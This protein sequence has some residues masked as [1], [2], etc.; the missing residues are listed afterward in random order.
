ME[1]TDG[2]PFSNFR[3][4]IL[5][6]KFIF[7]ILSNIKVKNCKKSYVIFIEYVKA[8]VILIVHSEKVK[9]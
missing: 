6:K 9:K 7:Q 3:P 5:E 8:D 1:G 2:A 4:E